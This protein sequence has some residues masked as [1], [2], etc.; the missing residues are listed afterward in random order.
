ML[1][2]HQIISAFIDQIL[3]PHFKMYNYT[4]MLNVILLWIYLRKDYEPAFMTL[5]VF[6]IV[7]REEYCNQNTIVMTVLFP[8]F[9]TIF[10]P[11]SSLSV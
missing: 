10:Y 2:A 6:E 5:G 3:L 4:E 11:S 8:M 9:H 7:D 1:I